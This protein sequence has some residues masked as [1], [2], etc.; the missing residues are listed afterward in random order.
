MIKNVACLLYYEDEKMN[1]Q[2]FLDKLKMALN[3]RIAPNL[4]EENVNYYADYI[5]TQIRMGRSEQE[6]LGSLGDPRLIARTIAET[7][8]STGNT[9]QNGYQNEGTYRETYRNENYGRTGTTNSG[10]EYSRNG[11]VIR[12]PGW[13][14]A[15]LMMLVMVFVFSLIFSVLSFLAPIVLPIIVVLFLVKLFRD[16]LN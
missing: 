1:K 13:L 3:G 2:E 6:V 5:H 11:K 15:I 12:M 10:S 14:M 16:W 4:V 8:G 9:G 7:Q